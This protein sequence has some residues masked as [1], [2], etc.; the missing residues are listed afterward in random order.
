MK[1]A[2]LTFF[3]TRFLMGLQR[4]GRQPPV[5][6]VPTSQDT[7]PVTGWVRSGG[8]GENSDTCSEAATLR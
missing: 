2:G 7:A 4:T 1:L 3:R 5:P 8:L 6:A